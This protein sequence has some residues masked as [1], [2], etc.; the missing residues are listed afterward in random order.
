MCLTKERMAIMFKRIKS[1]GR[2]VM[3]K[4]FLRTTIQDTAREVQALHRRMDEMMQCL[5]T[6]AQ[7]LAARGGM[8]RQVADQGEQLA[9]RLAIA[10]LDMRRGMERASARQDDRL[11]RLEKA[12]ADLHKAQTEIRAAI[13]NAESHHAVTLGRLMDAMDRHPAEPQTAPP[14]GQSERARMP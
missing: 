6:D 14:G 1:L 9:D 3:N 12:L 7:G 2:R 8:A 5:A 4:L 11:D 10:A 13:E